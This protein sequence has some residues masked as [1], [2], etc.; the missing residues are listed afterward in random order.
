MTMRF[1]LN[2]LYIIEVD[3]ELP[4][5]C[6]PIL[7]E[8]NAFLISKAR[9]NGFRFLIFFSAIA[10]IVIKLFAVPSS[11]LKDFCLSVKEETWPSYVLLKFSEKIL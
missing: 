7:T 6:R 9:F 4:S 5:F 10:C 8:S 11:F 3:P 1:E 2:C